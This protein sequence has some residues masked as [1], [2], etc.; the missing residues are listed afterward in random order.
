M[1]SGST[2]KAAVVEGLGFVGIERDPDH[3]EI[4]KAR[5]LDAIRQRDEA[6]RLAS[7]QL[8]MFA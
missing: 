2:G 1:G 4:A 6:R 3:F 8:E 7:A 5:I